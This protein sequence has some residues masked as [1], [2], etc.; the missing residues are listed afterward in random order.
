MLDELM[1]ILKSR[2]RMNKNNLG[3]VESLF[4]FVLN[5]IWIYLAQINIF[6]SSRNIRSRALHVCTNPFEKSGRV[7]RSRP[8]AAASMMTNSTL[9]GNLNVI[10]LSKS[11]IIVYDRVIVMDGI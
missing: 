11:L 5:D 4:C 2:Q 7:Y 8:P 10:F 3:R 6:A 1:I 9:E